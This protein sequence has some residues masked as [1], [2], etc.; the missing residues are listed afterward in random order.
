MSPQTCSVRVDQPDGTGSMIGYWSRLR[1]TA[2]DVEGDVAAGLQR[3]M[4]K[5]L[6]SDLAVGIRVSGATTDRVTRPEWAHL[7]DLDG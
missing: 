5:G 6:T 3:K 2:L 7:R 1:W 4:E